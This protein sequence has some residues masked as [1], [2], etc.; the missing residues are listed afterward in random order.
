MSSGNLS[1]LCL[2]RPRAGEACR[3][4]RQP[5][6]RLFALVPLSEDNE[7]PTTFLEGFHVVDPF[8]VGQRSQQI[9]SMSAPI[10]TERSVVVAF[11]RRADFTAFILDLMDFMTRGSARGSMTMGPPGRNHRGGEPQCPCCENASRRAIS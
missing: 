4:D 9:V 8:V 10:E 3:S 2:G 6:L 7:T 1:A 5:E 11:Q